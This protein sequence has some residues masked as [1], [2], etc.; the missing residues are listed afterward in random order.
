M[1]EAAFLGLFWAGILVQV[2]C[3][4]AGWLRLRL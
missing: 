2:G 4:L 1:I 3:E